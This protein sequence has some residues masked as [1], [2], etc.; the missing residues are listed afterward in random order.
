MYVH[1]HIPPCILFHPTLTFQCT[2]SRHVEVGRGFGGSIVGVVILCP[3]IV[4]RGIV[5]R[6]IVFGSVV[7]GSDVFRGIRGCGVFLI[8][9]PSYPS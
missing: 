8:D 3:G 2:T 5:R 1:S 9:E 6:G 7:F 4:R